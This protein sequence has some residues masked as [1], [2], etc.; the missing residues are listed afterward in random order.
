MRPPETIEVPAAEMDSATLGSSV[1]SV[2]DPSYA[3]YQPYVDI[4]SD[5]GYEPP[6]ETAGR[7]VIRTKEQTQRMEFPYPSEPD[8]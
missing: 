4:L 1:D 8:L 7:Q 2:T 3:F 5:S 6:P